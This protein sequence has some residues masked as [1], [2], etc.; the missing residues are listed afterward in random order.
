MKV[1][2]DDLS[3]KIAKEV[4]RMLLPKV[5]RIV[6]EEV[7]YNMNKILNEYSKGRKNLNSVVDF[8][9]VV[10]QERPQKQ[11]KT[12]SQ[13]KSV[14][15]IVLER[16]RLAREKLHSYYDSND[17]FAD[18]IANA[19]DPQEAERIKEEVQINS[20]KDRKK[21]SEATADELLDPLNLDFSENVNAMESR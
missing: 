4:T 1:K 6:R 15:D 13:E 11:Q 18:M 21:L 20:K 9:E 14:N 5:K 3:T 19:E 2:T 10:E 16:K 12:V 7:E 17:P 8:D